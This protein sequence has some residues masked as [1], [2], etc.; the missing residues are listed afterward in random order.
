MAGGQRPVVLVGTTAS[1]KSDL[2]FAVASRR[3][4]IEIVSV[5]S[6]SVYREMDIAT[7]KPSLAQRAAVRHH[8]IDLV[9]PAEEFTVS[10]FKQRAGE[11]LAEISGRGATPLL[12][13]GT[14]LYVRAIVDD[15]ALPGRWPE[16]A[17]A[18][19]EEADAA[20]D[21]SGL[22]DRLVALD[23]L[24]ASRITPE[25][26]RRII[27]ALEVTVGSGR[28]FSSFGPGLE[29]YPATA[30]TLIGIRF[31]PVHVDRAIEER[32]ARWMDGG[33]LE[34]VRALAAR[35]GGLSRTARQALGYRE[36]LDHLEGGGP[37][38]DA[39]ARAVQRTRS[40]ARRQWAWFRRDPRISWLGEHDDPAQVLIAALD[41][42]G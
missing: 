5:D 8:L 36:L 40:F 7:A 17:A 4:D 32:F 30:Y 27:R 42:T 33:L 21:P 1:G 37:L 10:M 34:E 35:P 19:E 3:P 13:G 41:G 6:M 26:R 9:D 29:A 15:L 14:G 28:P 2:A 16:V 23:P 39:V 38:A 20:G 11:A 12:V 24:A 25:N 31:D 18:L 22:Y